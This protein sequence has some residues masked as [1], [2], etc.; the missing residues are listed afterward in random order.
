VAAYTGMALSE[1]GKRTLLIEQGK[2]GRSLDIIAAAQNEAVFDVGDIIAGRCDDEKAIVPA[3]YTDRLFLIPA[4]AARGTQDPD[5][6]VALLRR[7]YRRNDFTIVD[8]VDFS[9]VPPSLFD[10][11]LMVTTPDTLSARACRD[12][13]RTL[14]N[15][16]AKDVRLVINRVPPEVVPIYGVKDFDGLID[17]IGAQLIGVIPESPKLSY[18]ANHSKMLDEESITIRI[19]DN[20]AARLRGEARPLLIR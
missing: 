19:F 2:D 14:Y 6:F 1:N 3:S 7:Q 12:E 4:A 13:T 16:G 8:G 5:S 17:L 15:A 11:I 9:V 18:A 10:M 20:L